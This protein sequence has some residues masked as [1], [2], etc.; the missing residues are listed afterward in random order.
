[1]SEYQGS[2][3]DLV[4][5]SYVIPNSKVARKIYEQIYKVQDST[6]NV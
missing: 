4:R 6:A 5:L 3:N 1:M 2:E